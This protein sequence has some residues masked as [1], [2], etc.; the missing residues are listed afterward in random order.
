M[1]Y[2]PFS[3]PFNSILHA[4]DTLASPQYPSLSPSSLFF[5]CLSLLFLLF[6]PSCSEAFLIPNPFLMTITCCSATKW[7][8]AW[9]R[10]YY[11][12]RLLSVAW[13]NTKLSFGIRNLFYNS[14]LG[15]YPNLYSFHTPLM[16]MASTP[17]PLPSEVVGKVQQCAAMDICINIAEDA[18]LQSCSGYG[19]TSG[20]RRS[21]IASDKVSEAHFYHN[22]SKVTHHIHNSSRE[23]ISAP[24][25]YNTSNPSRHRLSPTPRTPSVKY[26]KIK[27]KTN[28]AYTPEQVRFIQYLHEDRKW[29][30]EAIR[31]AFSELYP[32]AERKYSISG[33]QCRFYRAQRFPIFVVEGKP[34]LDDR[35]KIIMRQLTL[36][37]RDRI[38][39]SILDERGRPYYDKE[40]QG[41]NAQID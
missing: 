28:K 30:W 20:S 27:K 9:R 2:H 10:E 15:F 31:A 7:R 3:F 19:S 37:E 1:S 18:Y 22:S 8:I 36:R 38:E 21:S 33:V 12:L 14:F 41:H 32:D 16:D 25:R 29:P 6:L 4:L 39:V 40:G 17:N 24:F 35:G 5:F 11:I 13:Y 23:N 34:L 26:R